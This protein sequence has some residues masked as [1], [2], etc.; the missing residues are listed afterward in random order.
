MMRD[1]LT[2]G[3]SL[4]DEITFENYLVGCNEEVV[5][6]LKQ[7]VAKGF[8]DYICLLGSEGVGKSHLLQACCQHAF[9]V[10]KSAFYLP[11][12]RICDFSPRIVENLD[13]FYLVCIDDIQLIAG[14]KEWQEALF[15]LFNRL[16][17]KGSKLLIST[18]GPIK[19]LAI[20]LPDLESR[21]S[22]G[23]VYVLK[24][25]TDSQKIAALQCRAESKGLHLSISAGRFLLNHYP[26]DLKALLACLDILDEASLKAQHRLTVPF[27]KTVLN[28]YKLTLVPA[29]INTGLEHDS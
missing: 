29:E 16:L 13:D 27:I 17:Q 8:P 7:L 5:S 3:I 28:S 20:T 14:L 11:L 23:V 1:Q 24:P 2:L 12:T 9:S 19:H 6:A 4:R 22:S 21:L 18:N 25:L 10:G 26:R 15:Y